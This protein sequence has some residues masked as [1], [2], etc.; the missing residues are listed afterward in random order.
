MM[1][2]FPGYQILAK[3]YESSNSLVYRGHRESDNL[4]VILKILHEDY[5]PP[6]KLTRYKQEFE[7]TRSLNLPGVVK[8]YGL[9]NYQNTLAMILEDFGGE[10]LRILMSSQKFTFLGFLTLAIKITESLG[11]LHSANV[12]HKDINPS[13]VVVNPLT[14]QVKLIDFSISS[15]L[16]RE[17]PTLTNPSVLEGTLAYM[18]PEQTGRMNRTLDYRTDFYSLGVTFYEILTHQLPFTATDPMELVHC[19]I[20][21][22]PVPPHLVNPDVPKVISEIVMKLLA[23]AAEDR[24][25]SAYGLKADLENCLNQLQVTGYIADFALG[26]QDIAD[27]FQIP[28]KLY[29]REREVETLLE[30]FERV[31]Q[32]TTEIMLVAGYSGVGKS[33]LVQEIYKPITRKYGYF[34]SGKFDQLQRSIPYSAIVSA[35]SELVRLLL[36]ETE[37]QLEAWRQKLTHALGPNGQI[38]IDVI[39]EVEWIIGPQSPVAELGP[40][41]TQNRFNQVFQNFIRVFCQPEH[42]LAIFLDDLQWADSATL[43]LIDL[44]VT[45]PQ[46]KHLFLIGAYRDN[47]VSSTHPLT[48]V[49]DSL[50]Q[51][52][53]TVNQINLVPLKL[54]K[55]T[56]LIADTLHSD[57]EGIKPLAELTLRKTEGN[58]FFVNEFLKTLYQEN[59]LTFTTPQSGGIGRWQWDIAQIEAIAITDNVVD[60][61]IRK[62]RKLPEATQQV[63]RLVACLGN[64]FDL[65]TLS[66]IY[67][68]ESFETFQDLLP[69]IQIGL[70]Q[71]TSELEAT[72]AEAINSPLLILN[73]KFLHDR[74]QQAAYTLIDDD[75]KKVV[76]LRIGRLL[77]A[78]TPVEYRSER[79][80][81]LI[82]HLNIGRSLIQDK[83]ELLELA[84]L[85]LEAAKK[86]KDATA[87]VAA[88]EYLTA[89]MEGLGPEIWQESYDLAL[90]LHKERAEIEHLN[91]NFEESEQFI[92]ITLEQVHSLLEKTEI[93]NLLLIQYTLQGKSEEAIAAAKTALS[94]LGLE[95]PETD[96]GAAIGTEL[97]EAK[98]NLGDLPISELYHKPEMASPEN[99]IALKLLNNLLPSAYFRSAELWTLVALKAVNL[100]LKYGDAPES[101]P[102]Y[103][104]YGILLTSIFGDYKSAYEFGVVSL[105]LSEKWRRLDL[106]CKVCSTLANAL[107]FW[108]KPLKESNYLNNEGYQ[109]G[110]DSGDLQFAGYILNYKATNFF[111]QG[112]NLSQIL[113]ELPGYL[114]FT[115]KSKNQMATDT[116]Q[117]LEFIL[118]NLRKLTEHKL[119]FS[120]ETLDDAVFQSN[121]E[122]NQNFYSLC[123]YQILKLQIL[124]LYGEFQEALKLVETIEKN[125]QF[126]TGI[127]VSTE[128][129]FYNSLLLAALYP[130]ATAEEQ[131]RYL[132]KIESN[133][134]SLKIWAENSAENFLHKLLFVEAEVARALG[135]FETAL[136]LYEQAISTARENDFIQHESLINE[137][138]ALFWVERNKPKYVKVHIRDAYFGYQRWGAIRKTEEL[139]TQYPQF[140]SP[141]RSPIRLPGQDIVSVIHTST[142]SRSEVLDLGTVMKASQAISSE[143]VLDKLLS[144]LMRILIENAGAQKGFLLLPK[145]EGLQIAAQASVTQEQVVIRDSALKEAGEDLPIAI[146]HYVERTLTDVV[147]GHAANDGRFS[148]DS[149]VVNQQLKSILCTPIVNHGQ[150]IGILYLENN[151]IVGAFTPERLEVLRLLSSQTAISLE[152]AL[153][154]A[155]MEQKVQQRTQELNDKNERLS[156]A[157]QEL[158]KTQAQ[159]IQTE[160]M[161]GLGQMVAGIAH[162]INN[163]ISFI[164]GNIEHA[165]NYIQDIFNLLRAYQQ[166]VPQPSAQIQTIIDRIDLD[167]LIE[168]LQNLLESMQVGAERI[169]NIILSLRNFSRLD[170]ASMKPVDIH[171]GID[172]TVMLLQPRLRA[173]GDRTEIEIRREY[174]E[175]P[176][177]T[178]YA[179]QLN[180]VFMNI[181]TNA[182][183]AIDEVRKQ[184]SDRSFDPIITIRTEALDDR[185]IKI[186]IID[187]GP[188]MPEDVQ[189]RIFDPFFT[190]KPVGS[191]TGLGL[192]ISYSIIVDS[193]GGQLS[194][195]SLPGQG[196]EFIIQI[197]KQPQLLNGVQ[198]KNSH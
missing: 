142:G 80:F 103:G 161:S 12:I 55:V 69:A 158:R 78:S 98:S 16:T 20:A 107:N 57:R 108:F 168:D 86:A 180:Q 190:T 15:I 54:E 84:T 5:P 124:Y 164:Y 70:I 19:H 134:K 40:T 4:P 176:K 130:T 154:Y 193:H 150:L 109:A 59:L 117:G 38:I 71:A 37:A 97:A 110:L 170:E 163:P 119:A 36:T 85:N 58:P 185:H 121:C 137:R 46:I 140:C 181:L 101:A 65:N 29:G 32:G 132:E 100:S 73:Y 22:Q 151:L 44:I 52:N 60:L 159:L 146:I 162:E 196:S 93:Y 194:C 50:V 76:H 187:N 17:T 120:T 115:Q 136:D 118:L 123:I 152:N 14:G 68:K 39:P 21:K 129:N 91:S 11:E 148:S 111:F 47:E 171:S 182:I 141:S 191:G 106:K 82:D 79:I 13:N 122:Q 94:L 34:V 88:R 139:E 166:E 26:S 125:L 113:S 175:L 42:P 186:Q 143:I 2:D 135:Q 72:E 62:L 96:I 138:V 7:I 9:Q 112:R 178:C 155:S 48:I 51:E 95:I 67:E 165:N 74:V 104:T 184:A 61:M 144:S 75:R 179:S 174:S 197:P 131:Q 160:K 35:F 27:K 30:A 172:S 169:R 147:L 92:Q 24:Y 189:K 116:I 173:E 156:K 53:V 41:E 198:T 188:G 1:I 126:V 43:K 81:E 102:C 33:A 63:L 89:A 3:I 167:F 127:F 128:F 83:G 31:S 66:L 6:E 64:Q 177:I 145:E 77:L 153:L 87:Y 8:A 149:Y 183:D 18:S 105:K 114:Q 23:K 99:K 157:L 49:I 25:Q 56:Q 28:Q 195:V 90:A 192:S 45:D 10:S 133:Q